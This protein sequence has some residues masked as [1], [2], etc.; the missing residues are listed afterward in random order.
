MSLKAYSYLHC[1]AGPLITADKPYCHQKSAN[2][3]SVPK[4][5]SKRARSLGDMNGTSTMRELMKH[6]EETLNY[7]IL[8][9]A[10]TSGHYANCANRK[11][12]ATR[13]ASADDRRHYVT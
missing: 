12:I 13:S 5:R 6:G 7:E 10:F 9:R 1:E 11:V 4:Y 8:P 2:Y 3:I